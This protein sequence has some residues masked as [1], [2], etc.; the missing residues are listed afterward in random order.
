MLLKEKQDRSIKGCG[1]LDGIK[2]RENIEPKDATSPTV[3]TESVI[4]IATIDA[5]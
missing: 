4:L 3:S 5:L 2:Q 1:V